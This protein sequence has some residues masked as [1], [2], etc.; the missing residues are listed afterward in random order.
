MVMKKRPVFNLVVYAAH[1]IA[2]VLPETKLC[3]PF[4]LLQP[5]MLPAHVTPLPPF[6]KQCSCICYV[7]C[8]NTQHFPL[9]LLYP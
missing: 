3:A 5:L 6:L 7:L 2:L 8:N 1:T 9:P 4:L